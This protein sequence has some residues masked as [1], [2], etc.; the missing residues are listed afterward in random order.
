MSCRILVTHYIWNTNSLVKLKKVERFLW[1]IVTSVMKNKPQTAYI[2]KC[3]KFW[4]VTTLLTCFRNECVFGWNMRY[5]N[6]WKRGKGWNKNDY[7]TPNAITDSNHFL[8]KMREVLKTNKKLRYL[9]FCCHRKRLLLATVMLSWCY[10]PTFFF[11]FFYDKRS[12]F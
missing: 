5:T 11:L 10:N 12:F 4:L 1:Y 3:W 7:S 9:Y 8:E 6:T 2:Q